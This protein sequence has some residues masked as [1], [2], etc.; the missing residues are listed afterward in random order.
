MAKAVTL[1][2]AEKA[3]LARTLI[4]DSA[5]TRASRGRQPPDPRT[6]SVL[7]AK[8]YPIGKNRSRQVIERDFSH[9]DL[10]LAMDQSNLDDLRR[11]CPSEHSHKLKLFLQFAPDLGV[12][13][14]P[15]PYYSNLQGFER[16]LE[17]CEA[18]ALGLIR[19]YQGRAPVKN[20][21]L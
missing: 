12:Q 13:D 7:S 5:G 11:L 1:H 19:H 16:V 17:L 21:T 9:Y 8:G 6:Q 10:I 20:Q 2:W 4:I 18:G 3:G 15:D 14:V